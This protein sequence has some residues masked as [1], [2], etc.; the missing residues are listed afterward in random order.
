LDANDSP[1]ST[2]RLRAFCEAVRAHYREHGRDLPWRH[3]VDPYAILVSEVMLQ[4]TQVA[5]VLPKYQEFL[6]TFPTVDALSAAP[7]ASVLAVW[8]GLGYNR[9]A[10]ALHRTAQVVAGGHGGVVPRNPLDLRRLPGI[11]AATAAAVCVFAYDMPLVFIE[12][13]IRAAF[14][15]FFFQ[16]CSSV[17]DAAL[18]PLV[19]LTLDR[20]NPRDWYYALMDYG[21]WV[22]RQFA[23]PSR[24][25]SRY[26]V[27][28][29][30][31]GSHRQLRAALLRA[32]LA[33]PATLSLAA[34]L[35]AVGAPGIDA[36]RIA[37]ALQELA[38]EGFLEQTGDGYRVAGAVDSPSGSPNR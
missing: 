22:K 35:A 20:D 19:E 16:E 9:R 2:E 13:N 5:R 4:Q 24:R 25:S 34:V 18:L 27:Q 12:T 17:P 32:L 14:I 29:P 30:F 21:V 15:H 38:A 28:S 26:A 31:E 8:Q 11:G 1:T 37:G 6:A 3:T 10:L 23:N 36:G 7:I 33:A